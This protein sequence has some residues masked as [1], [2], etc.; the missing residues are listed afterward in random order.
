MS[1]NP[2][3]AKVLPDAENDRRVAVAR[4]L[5]Q[6]YLIARDARD[7]ARAWMAR[8]CRQ[9]RPVVGD[10]YRRVLRS[11]TDCAAALSRL[12]AALDC[13]KHPYVDVPSHGQRAVYDRLDGV[14]FYPLAPAREPGQRRKQAFSRAITPSQA[15]RHYNSKAR[16]IWRSK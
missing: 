11:E 9:G 13:L 15:S 2:T 7:A 4:V 8:E 14:T 16:R 3:E 1:T 6:E 12:E 10:E 5:A